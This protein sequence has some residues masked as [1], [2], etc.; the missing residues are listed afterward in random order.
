MKTVNIG[1]TTPF[2][3]SYGM[4]EALRTLKTNIQF[5]GDDI[6][7]IMITSMAPDEGKSS[8]TM[9]LARSLTE[10]GKSILVVDTDMRKS[11][12]LGRLQ[13]ESEDE[14]EIYGLSHYLSGQQKLEDSLYATDIAKLHIMFAGPSVPNPTELLEKKYFQKLIEDARNH[15]DYILVDTAPLGAAIDAAIVARHVDATILVVAQ[16]TES[17]RAILDAK[18]QIEASG[19]KILGVVL[20]KVKSGGAHY[21]SY[22][23]RYYGRYY[24]KYYGRKEE[25]EKKSHDG[26]KG[27]FKRL[28][29]KHK[30]NKA[31]K[32]TKKQEK[33]LSRE[34]KK[35]AKKTKKK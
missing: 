22:Y 4:R 25:D 12:L 19:G 1:N 2:K 6:K 3:F 20:N 27:F 11:V 13:I 8:V 18:K 16:D 7:V 9:K 5:S 24:G 32:Q 10:S 34:L 17:S 31:E 33:K 30:K 29:R 23:G 15:Y 26:L 14:S 28:K 21:G 35:Q